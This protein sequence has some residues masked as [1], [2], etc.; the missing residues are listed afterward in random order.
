MDYFRQ[1]C[2]A[3]ALTIVF[4]ISAFAG[5]MQ[6]G[7]AST[8]PGEPPTTT[9]GQMSCPGAATGEMPYG[10]SSLTEITLDLLQSTLSLF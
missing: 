5:E 6:F 3:A 8:S 1:I 4:T 10:I 9:T 2:S 7:I